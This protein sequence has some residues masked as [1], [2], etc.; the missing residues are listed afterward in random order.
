M[1][2]ASPAAGLAADVAGQVLGPN[3]KPA[4]G[5]RVY[6]EGSLRGA[7]TDAEGR[8]RITGL[9]PGERLVVVESLGAA[10]SRT[11]VRLTAEGPASMSV[12]L[13]PNIAL[14]EAAAGYREPQPERLAQKA[15][16]LA[17][18]KP[19]TSSLPNIVIILFDD[20]GW[21]DVGVY[22]NR[23]IATPEMDRLAREGVRMTNF[24]SASPVCTPSRAALLTGRYPQRALAANHVFFP[25]KS[26]AHT[27]RSAA[28]FPN[29]LVRDEIL[30]PEI[31]SRL[32]YRTVMTGKWHLGD[33]P[34]HLPNDLGFERFQG[35]HFSND[36]NPL[37]FYRDREIAVP[38]TSLRQEDLTRMIADAA[39]EEI[40]RTGSQPLFLYVPF[41]APHVPHAAAAGRAERAE[42]G[43]YGAVVE[44]AD[45]AIG[46]IRAALRAAG[47]E[48]NTIFIVTSDNGADRQGNPGPF[49]GIKQETYEGGMR[50]PL[51]A[52]W[53]GRLPRNQVRTGK[54][55]IFDLMPT[56]LARLGTPLPQDRI[57]DGRDLM[58]HWQGTS[59][60]PHRYLFYTGAWSGRAEAVRDARFKYRMSLFDRLYTPF[61]PAEFSIPVN[62]PPTLTDLHRDR[63]THDLSARY[64]EELAR[65]RAALHAFQ[66]SETVN[67]RGWR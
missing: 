64:P 20:L 63:E 25:E 65:L 53:P 44:E 29:A 9:P 23:L 40:G 8:F 33:R 39:V 13:R 66:N 4:A 27:L 16:Y 37:N 15:S 60:S 19:S 3:G 43:L 30:L 7:I 51:I 49:R 31:L 50:V 1:L 62:S 28:G 59:G 17:S 47:R 58:P 41:A 54:G 6:V 11:T 22:G 32:G 24:Y 45:S 42:A 67:P 56:L 18:I 35:I 52:S 10:R 55:M 21:G 48:R 61:Y 34:G 14:G 12:Q 36:M 38:A 46:R 2:V 26:P 57:I 5:A